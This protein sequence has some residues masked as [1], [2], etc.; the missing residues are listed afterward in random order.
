MT[1]V[2]SETATHV[3]IHFGIFSET[4]VFSGYFSKRMGDGEETRF[5]L[6]FHK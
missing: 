2:F 4:N 5:N 6:L 3:N 1:F